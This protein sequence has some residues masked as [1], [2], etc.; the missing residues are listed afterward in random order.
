MPA[1]EEQVQLH[2]LLS[3]LFLL[4]S[5][6]TFLVTRYVIV[7]PFG[8]HVPDK[9]QGGGRGGT[10]KY[11]WWFG[12]TIN[13]PL[14]W[15]L[16]ESPNL[17]WAFY[18]YRYWCDANI[19]SL[20]SPDATQQVISFESG[21]V[22]ISTNAA[23]LLLFALHYVNRAIVYPLRM[24]PTS[25]QVPLLVTVC[26]SLVTVWNGYLQC[27]YSVQMEKFDPLSLSLS[28]NNLQ[29]WT[30]IGLFFAG[31]GINIHSDGVLRNLRRR[32]PSGRS[33]PNETP[34]QTKEGA[35][36]YIPYSPCFALISCPNFFG[37]ILEWFGFAMASRF[38]LPSVAFCVYTASNLIP[39]AIA[40]HEWYL[41]KF[42]DYP[43]ER[44]WAVIPYV[45]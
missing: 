23:L 6:P 42:D 12:P 27:F 25:H 32:G 14:S 45:V 39:R 11:R 1:T 21:R 29:C 22:Q 34:R 16:F 30:G 18:C 37:E 19:F 2:T 28:W 40:H 36:Y 24:N 13:A 9:K 4:S 44:K 41:R 38:S 17:I 15:M 20:E 3:Q 8:R 33:K 43:T 5:L 26:A 35:V 31:M 7:A 10:P